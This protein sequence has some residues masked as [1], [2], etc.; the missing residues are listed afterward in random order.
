MI[1][2]DQVH[3]REVQGCART[4]YGSSFSALRRLPSLNRS[5]LRK[6]ARASASS[7]VRK[8]HEDRGRCSRCMRRCPQ[9]DKGSGRRRWRT[10]DLGSIR[11][12]V[13]ADAPRLSCPGHGVVVE[14]APWAHGQGR[15]TRAFPVLCRSCA[16]A[17]SR[18]TVTVDSTAGK[19]VLLH[20]PD[21]A[22]AQCVAH[23]LARACVDH[24]EA[25]A[26]VTP[27]TSA[28]DAEHQRHGVTH[29]AH[30]EVVVDATLGHAEELEGASMSVE[31]THLT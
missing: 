15:F 29:S 21:Q 31:E 5:S 28:G 30:L 19:G 27:N 7:L 26:P 12:F 10:L 17:C 11:A 13:E 16:V 14:N 8:H 2:N 4:E 3:N 1:V 23:L 6:L 25:P 20:F 9:Y 22:Q 18:F 24:V